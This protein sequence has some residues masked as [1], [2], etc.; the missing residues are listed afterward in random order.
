MKVMLVDENPGR[1]ALLKQALRDAGYEV[2][3]T[4][5][6]GS[7]LFNELQKEPVD[8]ILIDMSSPDRDL[9]EHL[10]LIHRKQPKPVILFA[11]DDDSS[12][13]HAAVK[14][15]VSAY[16]VD[17]FN[18]SRVKAIMTVAIARF[19]EYQAMREELEGVKVKLAERKSIEKAKG[20]LM[21]YKGWDEQMAYQTL[22][23]LAMDK[24]KKIAEIAE[25]L[26]NTAELLLTESGRVK[27]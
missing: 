14:A 16:V 12:I 20:L 25:Q 6:S 22:R 19:R 13:I 5:K 9:L 2:V 17:G 26:I 7:N 24:N 8:V 27:K 21:Q 18:Q 3:S 1:S 15:G 11:D 23:K 10:S 4:V